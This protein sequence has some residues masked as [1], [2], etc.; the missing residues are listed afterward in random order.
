MSSKISAL[1]ALATP[2]GADLVP[3]VD[4]SDWSMALTGT[5][6]KM[7]LSQ[8][9]LAAN[10]LADLASAITAR[11][12]LGLGTAATLASDSD[13]LLAA[14]SATRL[15][16][17]S[18]VKTYVDALKTYVDALIAA[19]DVMVFKGLINCSSNPNYPA[20]NCGETY[21][22]SVA[23]K[24]GGGS[25]PNVEVGDLLL[26]LTDSTASG[27][28]ATVGAQWNISQTNVD[29]AVTGPASAVNGNFAIFN[30]TSGKGIGDA[31]A[32]AASFAVAH[33]NLAALA[34]LTLAAD[35]LPYGTGAGALALATFTTPGRNLVAG[36]T[37]AAQRNT[38]AVDI[39]LT[40][41]SAKTASWTAANGE[42]VVVNMNGAAANVVITPPASPSAGWRFGVLL[43]SQSY[44]YYCYV[45]DSSRFN[46]FWA[47]RPGDL[48]VFRYNGTSWEFDQEPY[49]QHWIG[50]PEAMHPWALPVAFAYD[51]YP[52]PN[53]PTPANKGWVTRGGVNSV[54]QN[55][56]GTTFEAT[57]A[58]GNAHTLGFMLMPKPAGDWQFLTHYRLTTATAVH[59]ASGT[60][61]SPF[62]GTALFEDPPPG[63]PPVFSTYGRTSVASY[64][65]RYPHQCLD[66]ARFIGYAGGFVTQ[67]AAAA[68]AC[69][70]NDYNFM[71]FGCFSST[72]YPLLSDDGYLLMYNLGAIP[73]EGL[74]AHG[75]PTHIGIG[76]G[77]YGTGIPAPRAD[78]IIFIRRT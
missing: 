28:H 22:V 12:N 58:A 77:S 27:N 75:T 60:T 29:G 56:L 76:V 73:A 62:G 48:L 67:T 10:N 65:G 53:A 35:S 71:Y 25:G 1:G 32:S 74:N 31:G 51:L 30:G 52:G 63:F 36:A 15:A 2:N 64:N 40:H 19:N 43:S 70:P 13:G 34:G 49:L 50:L 24:I 17:Q 26:C 46:R 47:S 3:V 37:V 5:N 68:Y 7:T 8:F 38:L 44:N 6:K 42:L 9:L 11:S 59:Y 57:V 33:A 16:T 20:A 45:S 23:G 78:Q 55:V 54:T 61:Y 21:R 66:R 4:V 18:A 69:E 39:G 41:T 14:N 72:I